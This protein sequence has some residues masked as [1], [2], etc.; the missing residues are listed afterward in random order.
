MAKASGQFAYLNGDFCP[1]EK[2]TISP[3]DRGFLF[4]DGIYEVIPVFNRQPFALD[5]HLDRLE[6]SLA[7]TD[8]LN[9]LTR[10]QW[11]SMIDQLIQYHPWSQQSIYIQVTRG[12]ALHRD[13]RPEPNLTP[14]LYA[15]ASELLPVAAALRETG[16]SVV[17]LAD[18][19]W[20]HCDIKAITLLANVRLKMQAQKQHADDAI[21]ID[22]A[23]FVTE[24]TASNV[25][26][27][28]DNR[29]TT[30]PLSRALLP[31]ITRQIILEIAQ[32]LP[33]QVAQAPIHHS[34][35]AKADE[36]WLTSSTKNALPV[37]QLNHQSVGSGQPG[38]WW[39]EI[40]RQMRA[41]QQH[42]PAPFQNI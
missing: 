40:D 25:F 21:L 34:E 4:G 23:G 17:T 15:Y 33:M 32:H 14:T 9:P 36:I 20:G 10:T 27:V 16:L 37:T 41:Y 22:D 39:A 7:Q 6:N 35:L 2:C 24:A 38:P 12:C 5:P 31:G 18:D 13:H 30:P 8:L 3:Q 28:K 19:R 1:L 29:L 42:W 11:A 26:M